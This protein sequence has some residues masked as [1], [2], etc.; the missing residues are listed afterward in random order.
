[1]TARRNAGIPRRRPYLRSTRRQPPRDMPDFTIRPA[2]PDDAEQIHAL[3]L[4]L[5]A[6]E[7]LLDEARA[8][9]DAAALRA[10]LAPDAV[11]R[12]H[13][14]VAEDASGAAFGFA[15]CYRHYSTFHTNWG[16][17]LEDLYVQPSHRGAGAGLALMRAVAR[18]ARE[19]GAVRLEW[20]VLDWNEP[21]VAFYRQ[22]GAEG[23]DEWT[24][25]R[26]T[27]AALARL[28]AG[29]GA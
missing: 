21:A 3:I 24:T 8:G 17:Y 15:L 12:L 2:N 7:R 11:P 1:M 27:G 18:L 10:H 23:M 20:Q 22:L 13:G 14:F 29:E 19:A 6:Y 9:S 28:A 26:L 5:A 25:M 16:M 4:E